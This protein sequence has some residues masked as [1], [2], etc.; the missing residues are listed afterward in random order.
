ML[1]LGCGFNVVIPLRAE[2]TTEFEEEVATDTALTGVS[3][4]AAFWWP[5]S[6]SYI[7]RTPSG[8]HGLCAER[9]DRLKA[10]G[11]RRANGCPPRRPG[12]SHPQALGV[13]GTE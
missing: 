10:M 11:I 5:P 8:E 9:R 6:F 7:G 1:A 2:A 3:P 12:L 4:S 13:A